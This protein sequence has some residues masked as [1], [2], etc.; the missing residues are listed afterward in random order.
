MANDFNEFRRQYIDY[1]YDM[2]MEKDSVCQEYEEQLFNDQSLNPI[3]RK[4]KKLLGKQPGQRA[5][6][7][8]C[9]HLLKHK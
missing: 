5:I 6:K 9:D 7:I 4:I 2:E 8:F 3:L 1:I